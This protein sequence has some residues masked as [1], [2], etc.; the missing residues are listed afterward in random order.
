MSQ[1]RMKPRSIAHQSTLIALAGSLVL[2]GAGCGA[3]RTPD[4]VR[5]FERARARP[6]KP[7]IVIIP[8]ILGSQLRNPQTGEIVWP[9]AL[10]SSVDGLSL[11]LTPALRENRDALVADEIV[12][13][14]RLLPKLERFSPEVA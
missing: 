3:R 9:S 6:G 11:P 4:L 7:P 14:A 8:G 13:R 2:A 12:L 10:R 5:I 1:Q